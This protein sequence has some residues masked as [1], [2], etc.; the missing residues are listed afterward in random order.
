VKDRLSAMSTPAENG[1]PETRNWRD[2]DEFTL[3][4]GLTLASSARSGSAVGIIS[5]N[6]WGHTRYAIRIAFRRRH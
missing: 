2:T 5:R 6:T 1:S 3:A 4:F